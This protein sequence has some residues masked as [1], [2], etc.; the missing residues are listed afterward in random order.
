MQGK[1]ILNHII[2]KIQQIDEIDEIFIV[3]NERFY[4][5]F[6]SW[7]KTIDCSIPIRLINDHTNS[8]EDRLGQ[9]GDINL[10]LKE[11]SEPT[12]M[13][14][15]SGDNL[16]NF[17]LKK[18]HTFFK[19]NNEFTNGLYDTKSFEVARNL[20]VATMDTSGKIISFEEKPQNPKST[21]VSLGIYFLPKKHFHLMQKYLALGNKPDKIGYFLVW[22]LE[23]YCLYGFAYEEKWFDIGW[24]AS[25]EEA[26]QEFVW[27]DEK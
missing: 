19:E 7:L 13:L 5:H 24:Q 6:D 4:K 23:N 27:K 25:L 11:M 12:D 26:R 8:N 21:L 9:I 18:L 22:L 10:A 2:A 16:F 3:S 1:P 17:S 14:F 15:I 20:G